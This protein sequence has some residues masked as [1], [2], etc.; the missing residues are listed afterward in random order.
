MGCCSFFSRCDNRPGTLENSFYP[1]AP[2]KCYAWHCAVPFVDVDQYDSSPNYIGTKIVK[3]FTKFRCTLGAF[4]YT[5]EYAFRRN[6]TPTEVLPV[7]EYF[8]R[9]VPF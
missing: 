9:K 4:R 5:P 3:G 1:D 8:Y 7:N 6:I 2:G